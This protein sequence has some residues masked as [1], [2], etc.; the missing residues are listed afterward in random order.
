MP[1]IANKRTAMKVPVTR[2][3]EPPKVEQPVLRV[4]EC[5]VHVEACI[6][7]LDMVGIYVGPD[8]EAMHATRTEAAASLLKLQ[9]LYKKYWKDVQR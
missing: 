5:L 2:P 4:F 7:N 3:T 6:R 8:R 1:P 9:E